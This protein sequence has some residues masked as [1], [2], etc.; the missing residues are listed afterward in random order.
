MFLL[1]SGTLERMWF[2]RLE[3]CSA[4]QRDNLISLIPNLGTVVR[5]S[6]RCRF[7]YGNRGQDI[8]DTDRRRIGNAVLDT[9]RQ[10][11]VR[12][13]CKRESGIRERERDPAVRDPE[14]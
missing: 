3:C 11:A 5:N 9:D 7:L 12:I 1:L 2:T 6:S 14:S 13:A 4:K 10:H 8:P